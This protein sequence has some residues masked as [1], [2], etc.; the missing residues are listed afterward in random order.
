M[1]VGVPKETAAGE[2]RVALVP[3]IAG[4]LAKAGFDVL[5]ERGA[6]DGAPASRRGVRGGGRA[7]RRRD[8]LT[9]RPRRSSRVAQAVARTRSAR[10][11][12]G[13]C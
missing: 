9:R 4:R 3:D 7:A 6:G 2:R 10:L 11:R 12:E 13:R 1:V 8:E 5:V